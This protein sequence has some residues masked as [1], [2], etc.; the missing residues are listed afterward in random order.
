MKPQN[1]LVIVPAACLLA[2]GAL[3]P[4]ANAQMFINEIFFDP[5]GNATDSRDEFI[6]IRGEA[7]ASLDDHYLIFLENELDILGQGDAGVIE[8]IFD[9]NGQSLGS[10]G[11]LAL[12]QKF[13]RYDA[14]QV[15]PDATHLVN[16][17]P[18]RPGSF[19]GAFPGYGN[20]AD[21]AEGSSI[22]ASD[23]PSAGSSQT[24]GALENSGFTAMLIRNDSGEAPELGFNLDEGNDGLDVPT[25]REG[26][27]ILDSVGVFGEISETEFGR[28]YGMVNYGVVDDFFP[29]DFVPNVPEGS[30]Y[31]LVEYEI[32]YM[33]RWGN[34]TGHDASDWHV[35]NLTDNSG[36][37]SS[38]AGGSSGPLDLR[39]AGD[40]HPSD[41]G[42]DNPAPQPSIIETN[43]GVPYGTKLLTNVGGPN[44][45]TGDYNDD[46]VVNAAD[47]TVWRDTQGMNVG[48][49]TNHPLAD[50]N[51]DFDVDADDYAIWA[52]VYGSPNADAA[53]AVSTPEPGAVV[54]LMIGV[55]SLGAGATRRIG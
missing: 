48:T 34:S 20:D 17:G 5:G 49:Q 52:G 14:T 51:H 27:T 37:G 47:Y 31:Q 40:P 22:G 55:A 6:E 26:W 12:R 36:T 28:L 25:G 41:P 21:G 10:N 13:N 53:P 1:S 44:Y 30:A 24:T 11:F 43:Q 42:E 33:A 39:Q 38:G 8:N 16:D 7:G 4:V 32:E 35:S 46:G 50:H 3:S 2:V 29:P 19:P 45:L 23:L 54:L 18:N 15:N 9:L